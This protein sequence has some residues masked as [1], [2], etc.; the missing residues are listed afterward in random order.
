MKRSNLLAAL[1]GILLLIC[2]ASEKDFDP[3]Y[4]GKFSMDGNTGWK[5]VAQQS[6][7]LA[8]IA[9]YRVYERWPSSWKE[10][11]E[12]GIFQRDLFGPKFQPINPDDGSLDFNYDVVYRLGEGGVPVIGAMAGSKA[13]ENRLSE[14]TTYSAKLRSVATKFPEFDEQYWLSDTKRLVQLALMLQLHQAVREYTLAKGTAPKSSSDVLASGWSPLSETSKSPFTGKPF[15][16]DGSPN[17]FVFS[18]GSIYPTDN[19]GKRIEV[20]GAW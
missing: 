3:Q 15:K 19:K 14:P 12:T 1:V 11:Q 7:G 8:A 6:L 16:F 13:V 5:N 4:P 10:I 18:K 9:F 20:Y 2:S 17:D